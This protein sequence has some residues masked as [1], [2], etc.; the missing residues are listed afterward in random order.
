MA[1]T[2]EMVVKLCDDDRKRLD[3]ILTAL[4]HVTTAPTKAET[5]SVVENT[6]IEEKT[7][8]EGPTVP[9]IV[10][11]TTKEEEPTYTVKDVQQKVLEL[12]TQKGVA[13]AKVREIV[14]TY[15][16]KVQ[17]IPADKLGKVMQEL[18]KLEG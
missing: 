12:T 1:N 18:N 10:P 2:I 15:A 17:N 5:V 13:K 16:D 4:K 6:T 3:A 8:P 11:E 14:K 7:A 9:D